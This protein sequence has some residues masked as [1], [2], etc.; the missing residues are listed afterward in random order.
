KG[1]YTL[2]DAACTLVPRFPDLR[3]C[4]V[5]PGEPAMRQEL[6]TRTEAIGAPQL[7]M[8]TGFLDRSELANYL[9][10]AHVFA[11]PSRYEGGPGFVYLEAMACGLPVIGTTGSGASEVVRHGDTGVLIPPDDVGALTAA[12]ADLLSNREKCAQLSERA[13]HYVEAEADSRKCL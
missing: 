12:L 7:L 13:R 9:S 3:L 4:L 10:R 2:V 6:R 8:L 11:A 1:I 5:G